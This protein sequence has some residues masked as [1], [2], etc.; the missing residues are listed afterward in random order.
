M[1]FVYYLQPHFRFYTQNYYIQD[2]WKVTPSL[3][4]NYGLRYEYVSPPTAQELDHVYGFDFKT[5]KQLFPILGQIRG[6][7]ASHILHFIAALATTVMLFRLARGNALYKSANATQKRD[8][9][10]RAMRFLALAARTG[11]T[12][13]AKFLLGAS[14][15]TVSL[16]ASTEARTTKSCELSKLADSTLTDAEINLVGGGAVAPDAAKQYLD[17]VAKLRPYVLDQVKRFC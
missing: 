3:T 17:Y 11:P 10:Q 15:L 7:I 8:D 4:L 2:D 6:G 12:A 16:S 14:G 9:F 1:F 13:E 5:G